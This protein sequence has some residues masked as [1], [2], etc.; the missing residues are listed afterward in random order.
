MR[1]CLGYCYH[2][3]RVQKW[4]W[5]NIV[6]FTWRESLETMLA[7]DCVWAIVTTGGEFRNECEDL[8]DENRLRRCWHETVL[9]Y[10]YHRGR[11]QKWMWFNIVRFTWIAWDD[12]GMRLC[13]GY[14]YHRGRV[15]KWMWFNIVRFTWRESLETMLAWDRV[16]AIV[17]TEGEF[18]NE[19]DLTL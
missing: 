5:F 6:R 2:R 3:G 11:V 12:A 16:W 7:W 15:Q 18:R 9:G 19:C 1:L 8:P 14:C 13:W 4:M 17:T 10:C